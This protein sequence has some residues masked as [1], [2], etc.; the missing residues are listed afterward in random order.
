M[1]G[2]A[3]GLSTGAWF[4]AGP[5]Y[6]AAPWSVALLPY[7]EFQ[8]LYDRLTNPAASPEPLTNLVNTNIQVYTCPDDAN[9]NIGG[10]LSFA[11]NGGYMTSGNWTTAQSSGLPVGSHTL[12]SYLFS[13]N[14]Y[15]SPTNTPTLDSRE[16][17]AGTGVLIEET[18]ANGYTA[19]IDR[20]S[21]GQQHTVVLTENLQTVAWYSTSP[22]AV[23][24]FAPIPQSAAGQYADSVTAPGAGIGPDP[25]L[26]PPS[27]KNLALRLNAPNL[28]QYSAK[29]NA[30][31]GASEGNA[32][33]PSSN[34]PNV[35]NVFFADGHGGPLSQ[36]IADDVWL[37]LLSSS[38]EKFGQNVLGD[39]SF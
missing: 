32:P 9:E 1:C 28:G 21:D 7:L 24:V 29:I 17:Q 8:T 36:N 25:S 19:Q 11:A 5:V 34:H 35:V 26:V 23:G 16:V 15:N 6:S 2:V 22:T 31:L 12:N 27:L 13:F 3:S 20:L 30:N 10:N 14:N 37:R 18:G 39:N 38:G 33:R 4:P